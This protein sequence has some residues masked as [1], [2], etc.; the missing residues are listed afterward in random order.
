MQTHAEPCVYEAYRGAASTALPRG[1]RPRQPL[2]SVLHRIVRENLETFL[3]EGRERSAS[4]EGYPWYVE[5]EFRDLLSC[6]DMSR[7]F[8][9][10]KCRECGHEILVPFS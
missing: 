10:L 5:K 9:R 2:E 4:G 1:Y 3:A 6:G 7:G 8:S